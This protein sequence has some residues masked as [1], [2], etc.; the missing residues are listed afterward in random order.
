MTDASTALIDHKSP[1]GLAIAQLKHSSQLWQWLVLAAALLLAAL[2]AR[3]LYGRKLSASTV[4]IQGTRFAT[5]GFWLAATLVAWLGDVVLRARLTPPKDGFA[6]LDAA[7]ALTGGMSI[8]AFSAYVLAGILPAS[9]LLVRAQRL[10]YGI[11]A[12]AITIYWMGVWPEMMAALDRVVLTGKPNPLTLKTVLAGIASLA[13][14][15]AIALW[16]S[17]LIERRILNADGLE[18]SFRVVGAKFLRAFLLFVAVLVGLRLANVDL[19]LLSVFGGA[20]GVGL[21]LGLQK[22]ASNYVSGFIILLDRSIRIGDYVSVDKWSGVVHGIYARYTVLRTGDGT[23]AIIPNDTMI[24]TVVSNFSFTDK[25]TS[26]KA[27]VTVELAT[28]LDLASEILVNAVKG[29]P[30]V[31]PEPAPSVGISRVYEMGVELELLFWINDPQNGTGGIRTEAYR[32]ALAEFN[33]RG[34]RIAQQTPAALPSARVAGA[35]D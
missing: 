6:I 27:T 30:R 11:A 8:A 13:A 10:A 15:L 29:L 28:D 7:L 35:S 18:L 33:A 19:T 22:I 4:T 23:E 26:G 9:K 5:T 34:V 3:A 31:L 12:F 20:L 21:G 32:R 24:S 1:L 25:R 17:R 14:S 16:A 2:V